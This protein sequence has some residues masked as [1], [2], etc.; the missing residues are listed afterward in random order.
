MKLKVVVAVKNVVFPIILI[1][2]CYFDCGQPMSEFGFSF[3]PLGL[4]AAICISSPIDI[5]PREVGFIFP[6]LCLD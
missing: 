5:A 2:N 3:S 1:V 4:F 6:V